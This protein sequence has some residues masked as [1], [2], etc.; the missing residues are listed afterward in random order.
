[1]KKVLFIHH[2]NLEG[3][4][5]LSMLYTMQGIRE[6]GFEAEVAFIQDLPTLHEFFSGHGFA[7]H[8]VTGVPIF[9][10]WAGSEGKWYNPITWINVGKAAVNWSKGHKALQQLLQKHTFDIVHL[11]SMTLSNPAAYLIKNQ[12]P[13]VWHVREHGPSHK[14][15]R[16]KNI[17]N[18]LSTAQEVIFL[19][20]AEQN[21]WVGGS[22]H[23]TVVSNFVDM[24][25]FDHT[26][27]APTAAVKRLLYVGGR[28][29]HK[30]IIPLLHALAE[31]KAKS[32]VA[33]VCDMPDTYIDHDSSMTELERHIIEL[34]DRLDIGDVCN[35]LP[36]DPN[37]IK[38]YRTCDILLFPAT[39]PHF[40]RPIVEASAMG[41]PVIASN[42]KAVDELVLEGKTGY[43]VP[44]NHHT[45]IADKVVALFK[46]PDLCQNL[47]QEG[48]TFVKD[49]FEMKG[50]IRKIVDIY[51]RL[52]D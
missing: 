2:G 34:I 37:I 28:K 51:R 5:P 13:F 52:V 11:N 6:H 15:L 35:L 39:K 44:P 47:G 40:A 24:D 10:T 29:K 21:S 45:A 7:T 16:Y 42:V 3:G 25:V 49:N 19:S 31:I 27:S 30:G 14:G 48:I 41:K 38:L 22:G 23:G 33:F 1:M 17:S 43:L 8:N 50:Q 12:L 32:D 46:D 20:K 26:T 9:S 18:R 36:F 4:A